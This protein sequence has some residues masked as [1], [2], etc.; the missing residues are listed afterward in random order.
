MQRPDQSD[1]AQAVTST[2][3]GETYVVKA[4]EG[5]VF[6]FQTRT[7]LSEDQITADPEGAVDSLFSLS[8]RCW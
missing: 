7:A 1:I 5:E 4:T 6:P 2:C 3:G 8:L